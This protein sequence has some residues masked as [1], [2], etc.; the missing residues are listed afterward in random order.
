MISNKM[1][2]ERRWILAYKQRRK[3]RRSRAVQHLPSSTI[4]LLVS[5]SLKESG[6]ATRRLFLWITLSGRKL[7]RTLRTCLPFP[8]SC[9]KV[10]VYL[11]SGIKPG[12]GV[13]PGVSEDIKKL[14]GLSPRANY[15]DRATAACWRSDC[16]LLR[17]K[18]A[19][20]SA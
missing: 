1:V 19:T 7:L 5:P 3:N 8:V 14:R 16:Q 11:T 9:S 6:T 15:T 4:L 18:G 13:P 20:W 12:V 2:S 10:D 17:I